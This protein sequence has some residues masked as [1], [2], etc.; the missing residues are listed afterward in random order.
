MLN[1][2]PVNAPNVMTKRPRHAAAYLETPAGRAELAAERAEAERIAYATS[3]LSLPEAQDRP[4]AA[5]QIVEAHTARSMPIHRA[6]LWLAGL[7]REPQSE[8]TH[9]T[10]TKGAATMSDR[11]LRRRVEIRHASLSFKGEQGDEASRKEANALGYALK[12]ADS[13]TEMNAALKMSGANLAA[14]SH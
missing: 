1:S 8:P 11:T 2:P 9:T 7:P 4:R 13:G 6:K 14:L 5:R 10:T 3:I 12:L